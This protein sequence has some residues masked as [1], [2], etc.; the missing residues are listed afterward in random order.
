[1]YIAEKEVL[2]SMIFFKHRRESYRAGIY[3]FRVSNGKTTYEI[4][5]TLTI[6]TSERRQRAFF[7]QHLKVVNYFSQESSMTLFW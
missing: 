1:M 3:L 5:S 4:S 6:K 2:K 7:N